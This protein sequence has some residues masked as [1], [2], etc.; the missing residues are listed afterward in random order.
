[1]LCFSPATSGSIVYGGTCTT[2][3][4]QQREMT[5]RLY[6]TERIFFPARRDAHSRAARWAWAAW[7]ACTWRAG[8]ASGLGGVDRR[9]L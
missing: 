1:M 8:L 7:G 2:Y 3:A 4:A 6:T 9:D 5:P